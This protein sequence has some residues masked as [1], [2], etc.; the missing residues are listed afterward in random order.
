MIARYHKYNTEQTFFIQI[1]PAEIRNNNP[2]V[3]AINVISILR[4]TKVNGSMLKEN[5]LIHSLQGEE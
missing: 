3:A 2:R 4:P 1:N 5:I